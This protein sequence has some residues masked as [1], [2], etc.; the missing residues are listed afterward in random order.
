MIEDLHNVVSFEGFDFSAYFTHEQELLKPR[1]EAKGFT[2]ISF[3]M[4]ESD[5]FGP[6]SR[7]C[8]ATDSEGNNRTFM[9]G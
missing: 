8:Y 9:Y 4:G 2:A 6:L 1:L 5:S 7:V 3:A